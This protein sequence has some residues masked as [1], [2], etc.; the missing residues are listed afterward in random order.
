MELDSYMDQPSDE[1]ADEDQPLDH[2]INFSDDPPQYRPTYP[3]LSNVSEEEQICIEAWNNYLS[4]NDQ[5]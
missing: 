4:T 5:Q 2:T 3:T 1:E